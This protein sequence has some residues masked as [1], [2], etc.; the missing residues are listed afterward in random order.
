MNPIIQT[1]SSG[2][3][4]TDWSGR[5]LEFSPAF[6]SMLGRDP[7]VELPESYFDWIHSV[8]K[9]HEE[10]F[11][12]KAQVG[13]IKHYEILKRLRREDGSY[14]VFQSISSVLDS[15]NSK[16]GRLFTL[17]LPIDDAPESPTFGESNAL[18]RGE[19]LFGAEM[20]FYRKALEIFDWKQSLK[21][22]YSSSS[23]MDLAIKQINITLMQGTGIGS[24]M[25]V[26]SMIIAKAK[27]KEVEGI[28]E[29][30]ANLFDLLT[31]SVDSTGKFT[32]FLSSAQTL[33]EENLKVEESATVGDLIDC[34]REL[35]DEIEPSVRLRGQKF[36]ISDNL[37]ILSNKLR[38]K[39][40][41]FQ[42]IIREVLINA[43]KYSPEQSNIM[44]LVLKIGNEIQLKVI[45][46]PPFLGYL[47]EFHEDLVFE[48]FYRGLKFMD[49]RYDQEEFGMGLGLSV[50]KKLVELH[51]GKVHLQ[52][53]NLNLHENKKE[54]ICL[55][56]RLPV[57]S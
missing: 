14:E 9:Q 35:I 16:G 1:L 40:V 48:P 38:L 49:E 13:E 28:V 21:D 46:D 32:R 23:W 36:L 4:I 51:G 8:D 19:D 45:N 18:V 5:I 27:H 26:L 6:L 57:V 11:L 29:I 53:I 42:K 24:L 43:L 37:Q 22:R 30:K 15:T 3:I 54:G 2:A 10:Q 25:S 39:K 41:W 31:D 55:T 50:V 7:N 34:L 12:K 56:I 52:T 33:F 20:E 47:Q 44:V 17:F